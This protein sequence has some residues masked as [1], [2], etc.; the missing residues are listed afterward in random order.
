[1]AGAAFDTHRF[2]RKLRDAGI[3]ERQ[4]VKWM[5]GAVVSGLA[6]LLVKSFFTG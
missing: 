4:A 3:E 6:A 1:M 5:L 2:I